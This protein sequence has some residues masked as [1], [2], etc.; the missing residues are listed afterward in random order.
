MPIQTTTQPAQVTPLASNL[1]NVPFF[2][3]GD[4]E[5]GSLEDDFAPGG[6]LDG[7]G[8]FVLDEDT[9]RLVVN[10][11]FD[12]E[13]GVPYTLET[14]AVLTGAR[15][16]FFD[17]NIETLEL[18]DAGL[19]K[20]NI[21]NRNGDLV[22]EAEDFSIS[23][24]T[25]E[26]FFGID[27]LCS[28]QL[29]FEGAFESG[30]GIVDDLFF[31]GEEVT[32]GTEYILVPETF[33][34][35][36]LPALG[37][38]S[39]ES[40][41]QVD[42][43]NADNVALLLGDDRDGAALLMYVGTKDVD[44]DGDGE[45]SLLEANGLAEG[46]IFVWVADG[47]AGVPEDFNGTGNSSSGTWVEIPYFQPENAGE[48]FVVDGVVIGEF[49]ELGYADQELQDFFRDEAGAF[50]FSRPE[51][52]ATN[53]FDGT[54]TV[55]ASTGSDNF[56]EPFATGTDDIFDDIWGTTYIIDHFFDENGLPTT[57]TATIAYDGDDAG[58]DFFD[59][60]G[61]DFGL[62]S[63]DNLD[64]AHDGL[65]YIQEDEAIGGA[66]TSNGSPDFGDISG[67]ETSIW[68]LDP[69]AGTLERV[70]QMDRSAIPDTQFDSDPDDL[71]D[72]E[73]S[74]ILDVSAEFGRAP[75]ELI[76]YTVQA[77]SLAG[78]TIGGGPD[79]GS[80]ADP[81]LV[82][83]GQLAFFINSDATALTSNF[84]SAGDDVLDAGVDFEGVFDL[85]FSGAGSDLVDT[86]TV[87]T[88]FDGP[89]NRIY[90]GSFGDEI[91]VGTNDRIFGGDDDD[92]I[93]A[94]VG[95]GG[96]RLYGEDGADEI[97]VN[98]ND[99]AFGGDGADTLDSSLG[100]GDN[101]LYGG[102][103]DDDIIL[104]EDDRAF[105]GDG[106]DSILVTDGG[107]NL[108]TGGAGVDTF[109]I[110][111]S[112]IVDE[113]NTITDL[114]LAEDII[115]I[116]GIGVTDTSGLSFADVDGGAS[117][118]VGDDVVAIFLGVDAAALETANFAFVA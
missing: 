62:R 47:G 42:T 24:G 30:S 9:V 96:N 65:I 27:R 58:G 33:D 100:D 82:E 106:D 15:I 43:G 103:G 4:I 69:A 35:I 21:F 89:R 77:H 91:N 64:W 34:F 26:G 117:L 71:G 5:I 63:P 116:G 50:L 94:S 101:R 80:Q 108:I 67:E 61:P 104:G 31:S 78:G 83:G 54:Q 109:G 55:L 66:G 110:V 56:G 72:W 19:A 115:S 44:V 99:R 8:A 73:T 114:N 36:A 102:A 93:D 22:V 17:V 97:L 6:I 3:V 84:G 88:V 81:N 51:D 28:A 1:T 2:T 113:A 57:S 39:W 74:G 59:F 70:A 98:F 13:D 23:P 52:M 14:G 92:T 45:I 107:N 32:G 95:G 41:T 12:S 86:S 87:T 46:S 16:S 38:A 11:E 53:P 40:V 79:S 118:A 75:G 76:L 10:H 90:T 29:I 111:N 112:E 68:V 48:E 37:R 60:E 105:G 7:T 85:V 18:E 25:P 49:D 20:T